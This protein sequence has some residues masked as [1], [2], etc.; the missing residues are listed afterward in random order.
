MH[1][2]IPMV[3]PEEANADEAAYWATY[4]AMSAQTA[5]E[6]RHDATS[7]NSERSLKQRPRA[8]LW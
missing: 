3:L 5:V 6:K 1:A 7:A 8:H 4:S 2:R